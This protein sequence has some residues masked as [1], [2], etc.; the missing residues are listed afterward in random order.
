MTAGKRLQP[1]RFSLNGRGRMASVSFVAFCTPY[2]SRPKG[3]VKALFRV[4]F[5]GFGSAE[6]SDQPALRVLAGKHVQDVLAADLRHPAGGLPGG[7]GIVGGD[8]EIGNLKQGAAL[9]HR[10]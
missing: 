7:G 10:L 1:G 6:S 5:T 3:K 2:Y 8:D 4:F 9:R